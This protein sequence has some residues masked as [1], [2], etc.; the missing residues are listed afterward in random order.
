M[1]NEWSIGPTQIVDRLG[2]AA[3]H[4]ANTSDPRTH[5]DATAKDAIRTIAAPTTT[6]DR[7]QRCYRTKSSAHVKNCNQGIEYRE[8]EF[9]TGRGLEVASGRSQQ[10]VLREPTNVGPAL[11]IQSSEERGLASVQPPIMGSRR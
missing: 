2:V 8:M 1:S 5:P 10:P 6:L 9:I 7:T 3:R 4:C 11:I